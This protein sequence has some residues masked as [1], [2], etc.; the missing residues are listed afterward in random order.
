MSRHISA[1]ICASRSTMTCAL[2]LPSGE[3]HAGAAAAQ[4]GSNLNAELATL[5]EAHGFTPNDLGSIRLDL[6]PGSYTGL[7]VAVTFARFALR[8]AGAT[9]SCA[10]SFELIGARLRA[11]SHQGSV[12]VALDARRGRVHV[13][14]L[15]CEEDA[16]RLVEDPRAVLVEEFGATL[17][18][19]E[20][21]VG[22]RSLDWLPELCT[23]RG[24][25]LSETPEYTA[26]D[27]FDEALELR[28]QTAEELEPLYL[29][30]SYAGES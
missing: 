7:R 28:T 20:R 3:L 22:D 1:A 21:V 29:M 17:R 9:V 14:A 19:G 12:R 11:H 25:E 18:D 10:T 23:Q 4:R 30:G 15:R 24:L 13:G 27:L 26:T 16:V 6:G 2:R 8:F 5:F